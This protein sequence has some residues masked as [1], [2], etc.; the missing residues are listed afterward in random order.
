MAV[1]SAEEALLSLSNN[2]V[3]LIILDL[4]LPTM[5][6]FQLANILRQ[7][8][9][10]HSLPVIAITGLSLEDEQK[11]ILDQYNVPVLS[12]PFQPE[13]LTDSIEKSLLSAGE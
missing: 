5:N 1:P 2:P 7:N 8:N 4:L 6:G 3:E 12:K 11:N 9:A 10:W 13:E